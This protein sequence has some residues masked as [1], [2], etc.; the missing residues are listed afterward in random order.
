MNL[1]LVFDI[2]MDRKKYCHKISNTILYDKRFDNLPG[3]FQCAMVCKSPSISALHSSLCCL[4]LAT[5]LNVF[6]ARHRNLCDRNC[7]TPFAFC[8]SRSP[9]CAHAGIICAYISLVTPSSIS[10]SGCFLLSDL[11]GYQLRG[12]CTYAFI[13]GE[14]TKAEMTSEKHMCVYARAHVC[15]MRRCIASALTRDHVCVC[16]CRVRVHGAYIPIRARA[17]LRTP[18]ELLVFLAAISGDTAFAAG[19][20]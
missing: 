11:R 2:N 14:R 15:V 4:P 10:I 5:L 6:I 9:T 13:H 17:Y 16:V 1:A 7:D 18:R 12:S 8:E 19:G 3:G 20:F